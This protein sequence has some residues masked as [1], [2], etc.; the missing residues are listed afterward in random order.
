M[1]FKL[2]SLA[3]AVA[4]TSIFMSLPASASSKSI[5]DKQK[6]FYSNLEPLNQDGQ[7]SNDCSAEKNSQYNEYYNFYNS[8]YDNGN[9][10]G[11]VLIININDTTGSA[12]SISFNNTTESAVNYSI[13]M[14]TPSAINVQV[15]G[16]T[17]ASEVGVN[18]NNDNLPDFNE[19]MNEYKKQEE[20]MNEE[21]MEMQEQ[22]DRDMRYFNK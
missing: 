15:G 16:V 3:V 17:T 19:L 1:K 13:G 12:V 7:D 6:S 10:Y 21:F 18:I 11:N 2:K 5:E 4:C 20:K 14:T 9:M 22:F 8:N